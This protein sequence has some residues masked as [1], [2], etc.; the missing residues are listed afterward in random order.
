MPDGAKKQLC[1]GWL[2]W[3][4]WMEEDQQWKP[5]SGTIEVERLIFGMRVTRLNVK[6]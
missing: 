4:E 3:D 5:E 6:T 2:T 1:A